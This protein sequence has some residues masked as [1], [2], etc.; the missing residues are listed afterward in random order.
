MKMITGKA[1]NTIEQVT[2]MYKT[3]E[4]PIKIQQTIKEERKRLLEK[5]SNEYWKEVE[6]IEPNEVIRIIY[7]DETSIEDYIIQVTKITEKYIYGI[8]GLCKYKKSNVIGVII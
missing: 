2:I 3:L 8:G 6:E 4:S 5:Y 1:W 7:E